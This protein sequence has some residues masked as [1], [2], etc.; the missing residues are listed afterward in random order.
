MLSINPLPNNP[1]FNKPMEENI[2]GKAENAGN[3]HFLFFPHSLLLHHRKIKT[4]SV[5]FNLS[6][7]NAFNLAM[8]KILSFW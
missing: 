4:F 7:V 6:S 8:S 2:V 3:Q 5:I 1:E